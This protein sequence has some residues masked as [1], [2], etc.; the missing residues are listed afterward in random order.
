MS[1][2][3]SS[4]LVR[5]RRD[6]LKHSGLATA[7]TLAAGLGLTG[8]VLAADANAQVARSA[9]VGGSDMLKI[10]LIGCG[11]RG[12]GAAGNALTADPHCQLVAMGDTFADRLEGSL[13]SLKGQKELA[14]RVKVD[15]DHQFVGFDA[16]QKVI[17]SGVDVVLLCTTPHFRPQHLQAAIAANKHVF[18]E[19]PVAVDAPGV[20]SVLATTAEAEKK[21][22]SLVSGLCWR[23]DTGVR[24]TMKRVLDGAIGDVVAIQETYLTGSLS[25]RDRL[26]EW[27]EMEYQVRNWY[28]FT[29]LSGDHNVEQHVHS[30]DKA[31]WT[32]H[33]EPPVSAWGLGGRQ[34]RTDPKSFGDIYDHHAVVYQWE[35]GVRA[36][37]FTRQQ[38]GCFNDVND[39]ILGT[40]GQASVLKHR[41]TGANP[42]EFKGKKSNMYVAEHEAFFQSIRSG[43]PINNGRYMAQSTMLA[44]LGRM[45][46]YSGQQI[47]WEQAIQSP[48]VLAP[49]EYTWN[50]EP[51]TLPG[52]DGK[53]PVAMPGM[54]KG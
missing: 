26:P 23:Y 6:F 7:G 41:I 53:Y 47:T 17:D 14:E 34:V 20:R 51:P 44:I 18:C 50:A 16:F 35:N 9:H 48:Q 28:Y 1:K 36:F 40:K 4:K 30:L 5:S 37:A 42:W 22:L 31:M 43:V 3:S 21:K 24:E 45:V 13:K 15:K 12:T 49:K 2:P 39:V 33:D 52:P 54:K 25:H 29:W 38:Q 11:G 32:M 46:D 19:K 27:T 8:K 10:G